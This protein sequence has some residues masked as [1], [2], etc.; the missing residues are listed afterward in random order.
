[1]TLREFNNEIGGVTYLW[2]CG[3]AC[4][5]GQD[6]NHD[7]ESDGDDYCDVG[8]LVTEENLWELNGDVNENGRWE[9]DGEGNPHDGRGNSYYSIKAGWAPKAVQA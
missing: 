4:P 2:L 8:D 6:F 9:W 5:A 1:M 3:T 7:V